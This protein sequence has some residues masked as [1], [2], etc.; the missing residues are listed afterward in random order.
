MVKATP[1]INRNVGL[2]LKQLRTEQGYT[3]T[4]V[5]TYLEMDQS[6]YSK[7]E[8]GKRGLRKLSQ[9]K[10]LCDLYDCSQDYILHRTDEHIPQKW[11]GADSKLDLNII[12]QMNITMNY[13]KML[14]KVKDG[15]QH[16]RMGENT[17]P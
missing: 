11:E 14:R 4:Q 16:E 15:H 3:T 9:L 10:K 13:L 2:R 7:I 17:I 8:H 5:A 1:E 6:N 12:A